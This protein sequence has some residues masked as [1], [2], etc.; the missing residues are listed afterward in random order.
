VAAAVAVALHLR[1]HHQALAC[2]AGMVCRGQQMPATLE[3][4]K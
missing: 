4:I 2:Q 3:G 1:C